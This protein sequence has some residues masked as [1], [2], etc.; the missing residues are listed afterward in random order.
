MCKRIGLLVLIF[1]AMAGCRLW[2]SAPTGATVVSDSGAYNCEAGNTCR[3]DVVDVF[4]DETFRIETEIGYRFIG[5][6]GEG[7]RTL[8]GGKE[9]AACR[10]TTTGFPG[11][12][13]LL[14]LL[15]SDTIFN[16]SPVV[17]F[18]PDGVF[19]LE[20]RPIEGEP[21]V[22]DA[23]GVRIGS[24][25]NDGLRISVHF[26]GLPDTYTLALSNDNLVVEPGFELFYR[27]EEECFRNQNPFAVQGQSS[28]QPLLAYHQAERRQLWIPTP[29]EVT[30]PV[31]PLFQYSPDRSPVDPSAFDDGFTPLV[32]TDYRVRYPMT[33]EGIGRFGQTLADRFALVISPALPPRWSCE[34]DIG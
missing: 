20:Y 9:E 21:V 26:V 27:T 1:T 25:Q 22:R 11:N 15:E 18:A 12:P 5:W 3:F 33:V 14:A 8:C 29:D 10:L 31:Q 4:F 7:N 17:R 30:T 16:L 19:A 2:V 32:P 23:T 34:P 13:A 6:N 28:D 24:W